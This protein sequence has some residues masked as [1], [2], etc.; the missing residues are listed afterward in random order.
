MEYSYSRS[1]KEEQKNEVES[2]LHDH[3]VFDQKYLGIQRA[4]DFIQHFAGPFQY[5]RRGCRRRFAGSHALGSVGSC[6]IMVSLFTGLLIGMGNGVNAI[7][8]GARGPGTM[9]A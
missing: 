4:A 7:I 9:I 5:V 2:H 8:A 1:K 6:T 3:R